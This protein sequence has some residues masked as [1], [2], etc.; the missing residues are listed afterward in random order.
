[1]TLSLGT[2]Y[3][4]FG[5]EVEASS[6]P[7]IC[8]L[9]DSRR[10]QLSAIALRIS[11]FRAKGC[12]VF[13]WLSRQSFRMGRRGL[14]VA[15]WA[16]NEWA[17]IARLVHANSRAPLA[18]MKRTS[19]DL[20]LIARLIRVSI[21]VSAVGSLAILIPDQFS[22]ALKTVVEYSLLQLGVMLAFVLFA[23]LSIVLS[24]Q[25]MIA[26]FAP[27]LL[28][29][30]G[31]SGWT[32]RHFP[33]VAGLLL[34]VATAVALVQ[35][36]HSGVVA[37]TYK[38]VWDLCIAVVACSLTAI[39]IYVS[40]IGGAAD[41][42]AFLGL[43][44]A[45]VSM[46]VFAFLPVALPAW[47]GP[48]TILFLWIT[49]IISLASALAQRFASTRFPI[50]LSLAAAAVIFSYF[51]LND[52]H[53]VRIELRSEFVRGAH[54]SE[55]E[56]NEWLA[57]RTDKHLYEGRNYPVFIVSA[58]G[59]G[60]RAAYFAALV[61]S[62]IQ[63][64]CPAFAQHIFAI[65]GVSGGSVGAAMFAALVKRWAA[66]GALESCLLE[67]STTGEFQRLTEAVL[68]HDFFSPLLAALLF[69]DSIQRFLPWP[70]ENFDRARAFEYAL[71]KAWKQET[72]GNE[73]AQS[74]YDLSAG[75]RAG[76]VPS[77]LLNTT[78]VETG[79]RMVISHLDI[80]EENETP[81]RTLFD[82]DE[83]P[84]MRLST[85]AGLSARFP[86][87]APPG[88]ILTKRSPNND[89]KERYV[90]GGYFENT[91]ITSLFDLITALRTPSWSSSR[92][93]DLVILRIGNEMRPAQPDGE[94]KSLEQYRDR[95]FGEVLSP[96]RAL[97]NTRGARGN[98]AKSQ[99][100][101]RV[102]ELSRIGR[103]NNRNFGIVEFELQ[104][105]DVLLPLGWSLST[106]ARAEIASQLNQAFDCNKG[107]IKGGFE[108]VYNS[109]SRESILAI[110]KNRNALPK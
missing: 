66:Q 7:T 42:M 28:H 63:D 32:A 19:K 91:G 94:R 70:I 71:E 105:R 25:R 56:F 6:T 83:S 84:T 109:C 12:A 39:V 38:I 29:A 49:T 106:S 104:Q 27:R 36:V 57:S 81:L 53:A 62:S 33:T 79:M 47:L 80:Y 11:I 61:L 99:L 108:V 15:K 64:R 93:V 55:F 43:I 77:L 50:F 18:T 102:M 65:S 97:L 41:R 78:N 2:A 5:G 59:G 8:R 14:V 69:P 13:V 60:I 88:T 3:R 74:F 76:I 82:L 16:V 44:S 37:H 86:F 92:K 24:G 9:P 34:I 98:L 10:H 100:L 1:M 48:L 35:A 23:V 73:F 4:S 110:L 58:E 90:D 21:F 51:D 54:L 87:V 46:L 30:D 22:D 95:G 103:S 52:N 72:G 40:R 26:R 85:A 101:G 67:G 20:F 89:R 31:L 68:R 17:G 75:W 45:L 107:E 96:L